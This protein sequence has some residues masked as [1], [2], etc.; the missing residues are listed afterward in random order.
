MTNDETSERYRPTL[1]DLSHANP[2]TDRP[3]G[4]TRSFDRGETDSVNS[5]G[6][7][8]RSMDKSKYDSDNAVQDRH[9]RGDGK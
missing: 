7:N 5:V 9:V 4:R 3:F 6:T 2:H 1:G 8:R